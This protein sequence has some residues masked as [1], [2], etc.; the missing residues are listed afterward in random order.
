MSQYIVREDQ[1]FKVV[2]GWDPPLQ[3]FFAQVHDLSK[4]EEEQ[5]VLWEPSPP[6]RIGSPWDV[7]EKVQPWVELSSEDIRILG[8]DR[9]YNR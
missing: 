1:E 2:I 7:K 4:D 9:H 6:N 8:D 3:T 5:I